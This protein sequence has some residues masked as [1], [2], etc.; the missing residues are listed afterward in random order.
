MFICLV[1]TGQQRLIRGQNELDHEA[2]RRPVANGNKYHS[3]HLLEDYTVGIYGETVVHSPDY[4]YPYY[5][6][7]YSWD[8]SAPQLR[9]KHHTYM[10]M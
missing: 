3:L 4:S 6:I 9:L 2:R 1:V 7:R 8:A 5:L 10:R